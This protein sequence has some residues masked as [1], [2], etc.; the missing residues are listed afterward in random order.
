[1]KLLN[2]LTDEDSLNSETPQ[3]PELTPALKARLKELRKTPVTEIMVPRALI[4]ALDLD[5]Q[6]RRVRRLKSTKVAHFPVYKGDLDHIL[7]WVSKDKVLELIHET[8]DEAPLLDYL[9]PVGQVADTATVS[10]LPD[11]F[12]RTQSPFLVVANGQG[13]TVGLVQL[14]DLV[15]A[16]F[17]FDVAAQ[18]PS[19]DS[20]SPVLKAYEF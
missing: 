10:D 17:G 19:A 1:M 20:P 5:V 11:M 13:Q 15:E 6:L 18:S 3:D 2:W 9:R 16:I 14:S 8:R 7:G 4:V 12:L